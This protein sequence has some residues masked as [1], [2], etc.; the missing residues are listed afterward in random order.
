MNKQAK[1]NLERVARVSFA[2]VICA[3][4]LTLLA[5]KSRPVLYAEAQN[6]TGLEIPVIATQLEARFGG[7]AV[8]LS[9]GDAHLMS[10]HAL[11]G[12][13]CTLRNNTNKNIS[14]ITVAVVVTLNTGGN[15]SETSSY[16]TE[17]TMVHPD[18]QDDHPNNFIPPGGE[19]SVEPLPERY[20]G[21]WIE[22]VQLSIDYVEFSDHSSLGPNDRGSQIIG[23]I[24]SGAAKYK[25]WLST[26]Y[27]RSGQS[28]PALIPA[29]DPEQ[30]LSPEI[31]I[32]T[33]NEQQGALIYRRQ[34][35]RL[36]QRKGGEAL[37]RLLTGSGL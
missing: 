18:V 30:P 12:V 27:K 16:I 10:R 22:K 21:D 19:T 35:H 6:Q 32:N 24:R 1:Q 14:A 2:I 4:A 8:T 9:C 37:I 25:Q 11:E 29:L 28:L 20:D 31:N 13:R 7:S 15:I 17:E 3:A 26:R 33:G 34:A 23:E 5:L 36:Y